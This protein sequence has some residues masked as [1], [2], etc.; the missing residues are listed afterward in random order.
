MTF[1]RSYVNGVLIAYRLKSPQN[2]NVA[3]ALV[4]KLYGQ[5]TS[6]Q[7]GRYRY[8]RKGLLDEIPYKKLIRGVIIVRNEDKKKVID[9]LRDFV[10][11]NRGKWESTIIRGGQGFRF[12]LPDSERVWE[13]ELQ[14]TL[15][16]AQGVTVQSQPDFLLR[17]DDDAIKPV[18]IFADGFESANT[19][20]W[21]AVVQ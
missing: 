7:K 2:P 21:S 14:P 13:I 16:I 20:A 11:A 9:F 5:A 19:S 4:K 18:A 12:T 1:I 6:C 8:R 10:S 15:G 3:S 17:S